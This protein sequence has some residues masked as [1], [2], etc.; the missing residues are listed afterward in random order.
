MNLHSP[1]DAHGQSLARYAT[2]TSRFR[3]LVVDTAVVFGAIIL[4]VIA[5]DAA[6]RVPGSGRV[7]WLLM[8]SA[9]FLYE[10]LFIWR[11]GA[12]VGHALNH[13]IVVDDRRERRPTLSQAFARYF[14]KLV[15][16]IP[17][18]VT[19]ALTRRHQAVHDL[20]TKTTVRLA[21]GTAPDAYDFHLERAEDVPALLP[22]RPR[23]AVVMVVYLAAIFIGYGILISALD[24]QACLREQSCTTG[25][26]LLT[27]AVTLLWLAASFATIVAAWKGFLPGARRDRHVTSDSLVV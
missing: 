23:R 17:S 4:V 3:A 18:F 10:P 2:F 8:F 6:D 22:S 15:L 14:L 26:R 7:A 13:L 12:T 21:A 5:G 24:P 9:L 1:S 16:G 20:L 27:D 11:R 25:K 19:M